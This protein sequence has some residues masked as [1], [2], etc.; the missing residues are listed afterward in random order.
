M[1]MNYTFDELEAQGLTGS[2]NVK[3]LWKVIEENPGNKEV[4]HKWLITEWDYLRDTNKDRIQ[5]QN[6]NF[7]IYKGSYSEKVIKSSDREINFEKRQL[8]RKIVVNHIYDFVEQKVARISRYKPNVVFSPKD[9]EFQDKVSCKL[10]KHYWDHVKKITD[11]QTTVR[12]AKRLSLIAGFCPVFIGWNKKA[13]GIHKGYD[14]LKKRG[15]KS[16]DVNGKKFDLSKPMMVGEVEIKVLDPRKVYYQKTVNQFLDPN[17]VFIYEL[18]HV[19]E[20]KKEHPEVADKIKQ[21]ADITLY[22][23]EKKNEMVNHALVMTMYHK[24]TEFMPEGYMATFVRGG[25]LEEGPLP[26]TKFDELPIV[27]LSD[28][29]SYD[30]QYPFSFIRNTKVLNA[31]INNLTTI[32]VRNLKLVG[33]P[34]WFVPAGSIKLESLNNDISIVQY[35]GNNPPQLAQA[36]PTPPELYMFRKELK[37][38]MQ[39]VG[40]VPG[41]DRG[42]PPPGIKA[43]VALKFLNEQANERE[44]DS[45]ANFNSFILQCADR[46]IK[47]AAQYYDPSDDRTIKILGSNDEWMVKKIDP[48]V[49]ATPYD[50]T[51]QNASYLYES[52]AQV[53]QDVLDLNQ[54]FPGIMPR[55]QVLDIMDYGQ[56]DKFMDVATA[57]VKSA[58]AEND[59]CIYEGIISDPTEFE[60]QI[61]HWTMHTA[62]MQQYSFNHGK[63]PEANKTKLKKHVLAHEYLMWR[64]AEKNP[65]Y[66]QQIMSLPQF[67][68]FWTPPPPVPMAPP[69]PTPDEVQAGEAHQMDMALK[70]QQLAQNAQ[71][72]E[73]A[74]LESEI[75][76]EG[77]PIAELPPTENQ[78]NS[79][80]V[81]Q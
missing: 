78:I 52:K 11:F 57:A 59:Q 32:G 76:S 9:D 43:G 51:M 39:V 24:R 46:V 47:V 5:E 19:D 18:R 70:G 73:A 75:N 58:E 34:K 50:V 8:Q 14:L 42:E 54:A 49:L 72:A 48:E 21:D 60:Q 38:D 2:F 30:E 20:L 62:A 74:P 3:P 22:Y 77:Q 55:E 6:K 63:V 80:G 15:V 53:T 79:Q 41:V 68:M 64:I 12:K 31:Q 71:P 67:P 81:G 10:L 16:L 28:I 29:C 23:G 7:E 69:P 37:E 26:Y 65:N 36:N 66:M 40:N 27:M 1:S 33:N 56:S 25:L 4:I 45:I 13:G 17:Y 44:N 61:Q 35:A